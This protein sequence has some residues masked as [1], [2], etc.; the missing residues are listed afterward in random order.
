MESYHENGQV[1]ECVIETVESSV[2]AEKTIV[3]GAIIMCSCTAGAT[4]QPTL[5]TMLA[6]NTPMKIAHKNFILQD[7]HLF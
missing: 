4:E 6:S 1:Q 7:P 5:P 2:E 3:C